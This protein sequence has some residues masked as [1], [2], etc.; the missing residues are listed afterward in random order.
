MGPSQGSGV[1]TIGQS[2]RWCDRP[3]GTDRAG[4]HVTILDGPWEPPPLSEGRIHA[5]TIEAHRR[6]G[7][8]DTPRIATGNQMSR[9]FERA[10]PLKRRL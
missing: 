3:G 2:S 1:A 5:V 10:C 6:W 9:W 8:E 4:L 7:L